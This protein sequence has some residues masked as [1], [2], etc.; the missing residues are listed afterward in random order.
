MLIEG[1]HVPLA[2]PFYRDGQ[3]YLRKLEHNV[4]R[5]SLTPASA[6]VALAPGGEASSLSDAETAEALRAI[7]A[8]AA[9]E[10]VLVAGIERDSV[11]GALA[12]AEQAAAAH[13]DAVLLA[14][15][16]NVETLRRESGVEAI[17][18]F[19][20]AVA[21]ASP[22]PVMLWKDA[23]LSLDAVASLS[24]HPNVIGMY[25]PALTLESLAA[26]AEATRD[27]QREVTV[28]TVFTP[29]TGRMLVQ[30]H[31]GAATFVS[32][33]ALGGGAA[34]AVAPPRSAVKTRTKVVGF[35]IVGAGNAAGMLSLLQAGAAG[36]MPPLATCA[37][38]GCHEVLA[39]FKD[40]DPALAAEKAVRLE[41]ADA[42][43]QE[44]GVAGLKYGCDL[45]GYFGGH[46]RLPRLPLTAERRLRVDAALKELRN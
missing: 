27:V 24:R 34:V 38:Q 26:A 23:G 39:A 7:G 41:A 44:L 37:P 46:P 21:D 25:D 33:D 14:S 45:N 42:L 30:E 1:L 2:L 29:V 11:H 17:L 8:A 13:F 16:R 9:K 3:S 40:G 18:L 22:L 36:V 6:L 43:M 20:S 28:T 4:A 31:E 35:Q 5:Y 15:P 12:L 32:A 10:K 19:F